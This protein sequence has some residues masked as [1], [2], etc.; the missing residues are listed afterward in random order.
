MP[1]G[2]TSRKRLDRVLAA[3][4]DPTPRAP[5]PFEWVDEPEQRTDA[6][7]DREYGVDADYAAAA[8]FA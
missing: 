7:H 1:A 2:E 5:A 3:I 6:Q 8:E 4:F